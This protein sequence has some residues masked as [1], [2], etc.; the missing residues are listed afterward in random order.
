MVG[1]AGVALLKLLASVQEPEVA[2]QDLLTLVAVPAGVPRGLA[3]DAAVLRVG[4]G[5]VH[6]VAIVLLAVGLTNGLSAELAISDDFEVSGVVLD[7]TVGEPGIL[8]VGLAGNL[9]KLVVVAD[10]APQLNLA[11]VLVLLVFVPVVIN[12]VALRHTCLWHS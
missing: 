4:D 1:G 3:G 11:V 12:L 6:F 5:A 10:A 9:S 2:G 8:A 7:V